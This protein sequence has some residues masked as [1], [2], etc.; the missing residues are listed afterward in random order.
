MYQ[1]HSQI[2]II[3]F[4]GEKKTPTSR[5][6]QQGFYIQIPK[7]PHSSSSQSSLEQQFGH[8]SAMTALQYLDSLRTTHPELS[9][10][11]NTLADLYQRKLWHQ[12]TLKLEQFVALAV[13]Q[14][15]SPYLVPIFMLVWFSNGASWL[16]VFWYSG[17]KF[18]LFVFDFGEL[19]KK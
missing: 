9:D 18:D 1:I 15:I 5:R 12:L 2:T 13:F 16:F 11:Y 17:F 19:T 4:F 7:Q 6:H 8:Y 3:R 14:V 10:W